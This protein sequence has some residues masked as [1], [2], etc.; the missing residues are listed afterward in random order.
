[1]GCPQQPVVV[2]GARR[3]AVLGAET[4]HLAVDWGGRTADTH[5]AQVTT[6]G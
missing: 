4:G 3:F 1:M 6:S 2:A 5:R